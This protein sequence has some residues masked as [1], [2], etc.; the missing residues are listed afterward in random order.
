MPTMYPVAG[1]KLFIGS[2][3]I[4]DKDS[5]FVKSD[6]DPVVWTEVKGWVTVGQIG[7]SAALVTS[8]QVSTGRTKK[9]KGAKNAGSMENA[10]DILEGDP[11]QDAMQAA[12]ASS[13]N[14]P[15]KVEFPLRQGQ[16]T[17]TTR[18]F[19]GLVMGTPEQG[20]GA[21]DPDRISSTIEIN[22]NLVLVPAT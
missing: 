15:I 18:L 6:F 3:A 19:I 17:P 21:N 4:A 12:L 20:G 11:G 10:F 2:P 8:D 22:S 13:D 14:F 1:K 7:D 16:S 9:Q 5:D